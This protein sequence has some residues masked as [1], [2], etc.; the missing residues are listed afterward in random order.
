MDKVIQILRFCRIVD[1]EGNI[2][3]S[4]IAMAA[5]LVKL[6]ISPAI[7]IPDLLAFLGTVANYSVRRAITQQPVSRVDEVAML[8]DAISTLQTK[9][10]TL[11][12][13]Q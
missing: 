13:K 10:T 7:A 3:L 8:K 1:A 2:S 4:N 5:T 11:Q 6:L 9:V 12:M